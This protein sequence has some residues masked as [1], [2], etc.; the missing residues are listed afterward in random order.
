[1]VATSPPEGREW[2]VG[3]AIQ[4]EVEEESA[5]VPSVYGESVTVAARTLAR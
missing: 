3:G 4:L 1:M 5:L 2:R